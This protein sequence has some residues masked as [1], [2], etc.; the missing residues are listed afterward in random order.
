MQGYHYYYFIM[1]LHGCWGITI[2]NLVLLID[3]HNQSDLTFSTSLVLSANS[4]V[5][6]VFHLSDVC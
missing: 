2:L 6:S 4:F 1:I 5:K 3:V